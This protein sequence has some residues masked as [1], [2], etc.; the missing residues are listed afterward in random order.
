MVLNIPI[1]T[2]NVSDAKKDID[3]KFGIVVP[4]DDTS[5]Y[6]GMKEFLDN[7]FKIKA[8]FNYIDFNSNIEK[9]I[10]KIYNE[11]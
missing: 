6:D 4:N 2:T 7:G 9:E 1:I 11:E 10:D 8:K 3:G 5:I